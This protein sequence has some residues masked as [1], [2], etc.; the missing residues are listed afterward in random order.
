M[1]NHNEVAKKTTFS[2]FPCAIINATIVSQHIQPM[3]SAVTELSEIHRATSGSLWG[4]KRGKK[5]EDKYF[6]QLAAAPSVS[7]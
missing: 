2:L 4:K 6:H 5:K 7:V 3:I 1:N